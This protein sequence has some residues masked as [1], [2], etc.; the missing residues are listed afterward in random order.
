MD[1]ALL[2]FLQLRDADHLY[3]AYRWFLLDFK[4]DFEYKDVFLV[5]ETIW[6]ARALVSEGFVVL[7]AFSVMQLLR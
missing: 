1:P 3:F 5:W 7:L 4:R 6:A 2:E